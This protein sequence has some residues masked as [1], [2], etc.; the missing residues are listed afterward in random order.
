MRD[1]PTPMGITINTTA[2]NPFG[3][4]GVIIDESISQ[5]VELQAAQLLRFA[6]GNR[7]TSDG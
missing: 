1:W 4:S 6:A 5:L 2:Q 3:D 7:A